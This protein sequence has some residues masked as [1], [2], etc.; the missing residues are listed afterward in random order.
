[1]QTTLTLLENKSIE[2]V[3]QAMSSDGLDDR[4]S[5]I[6]EDRQSD[7]NVIIKHAYG[8][9][10]SL[11]VYKKH[12]EREAAIDTETELSKAREKYERLLSERKILELC[13]NLYIGMFNGLLYNEESN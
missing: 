1:M 6:I 12:P 8:I 11:E 9:V 13:P 7:L 3:S 10:R 5:R 4:I 2:E